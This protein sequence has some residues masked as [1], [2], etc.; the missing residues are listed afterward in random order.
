HAGRVM[1]AFFVSLSLVFTVGK[2]DEANANPKYA[3]IVMDAKTGK[4]LYSYRAD[5]KRYPASLTK[6]MTMYMMFDALE[7][8]KL[9]KRTRI[10]MS[11]YA[12]SKPP[13]KLGIKPGRSIAA[14][15]AILAL[16]TKSA[17]DVAA[18]VAEHLGGSE[19]NFAK[20]MTHKARQLGMKSTT[21]KNASGLTAKGQL[22]TARDMARLGIALREHF[23]QHYHYFSKRNFKYGKAN[24]RNHNRLLGAVKGVDGIKTGYTRASG[25][26]LVS[27]VESGRRSIV[28]VVIGGRTGKSRNAQMQKLI[29]QYLKK[30]SRGSKKQLI[31]SRKPVRAFAV[32]AADIRLPKRGPVPVFRES[33]I[34]KKTIDTPKTVTVATL[35]A[36]TPKPKFNQTSVAQRLAQGPVGEV[37]PTAEV[38]YVDPVTTASA[39]TPVKP[40]GWVIQIGATDSRQGAIGLLEKAKSKVPG[41]LKNKSIY[42]ETVEKGD[43]VL[44]RAR[45]AGFSGKSD[46]RKACKVLKRKKI[47]CLALST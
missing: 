43:S 32:A 12:A 25:F 33:V 23:P 7:T 39:P 5:S 35:V 20:M 22:T 16:A 21:F 44:H 38:A 4:T 29:R 45:F 13:S 1:A 30:A 3:G 37:R 8:G 15:H 19:A 46:A 26:N 11:K 36:E 27:S 17:N 14:E 2:A 42:T 34:A 10:R 28:A 18:A 6:M 41:V 47:A 31:A 9:T 40:Q 24:Y